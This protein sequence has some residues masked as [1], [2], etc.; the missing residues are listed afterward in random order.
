VPTATPAGHGE[1]E[2]IG[3]SLVV[4]LGGS[5]LAMRRR[6]KGRG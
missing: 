4:L 3:A 1:A 5:G 2:A 6:I